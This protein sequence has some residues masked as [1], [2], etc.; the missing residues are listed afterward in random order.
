MNPETFE[1]QSKR[2]RHFIQYGTFYVGINFLA[3]LF[4]RKKLLKLYSFFLPVIL[5]SRHSGESPQINAHSRFVGVL[6]FYP[7]LEQG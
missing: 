4:F 2:H 6:C 5:Y 3:I 1:K 7:A